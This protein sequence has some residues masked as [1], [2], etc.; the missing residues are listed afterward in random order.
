MTTLD[1][2]APNYAR[3]VAVWPTAQR[4]QN[5][6]IELQSAVENN[7]HGQTELIKSYIE[8]VCTTVCV[9]RGMEVPEKASLQNLLRLA[10]DSTGNR[11]PKD[12]SELSIVL[13]SFNSLCD[14]LSTA[15]NKKGTTA[16]GRDGFL[17]GIASDHAK[18]FL[19]VGDLLI[20]AVIDAH[21]AKVP[22]LRFTRIPHSNFE[23]LNALI[24]GRAAVAAAV[25]ADSETVVVLRFSLSQ[26]DRPFELRLQLSQIL[27]DI[28]RPL[29]LQALELAR[30]A[31]EQEPE[32]SSFDGGMTN[33]P[34]E[35][36]V[37]DS[38]D[39]EIVAESDAEV[40][41]ANGLVPLVEF[42]GEDKVEASMS[43]S[44]FEELVR[45][46]KGQTSDKH[47]GA[48]LVSSLLATAELNQGLDWHL[49]TELVA[50][51]RIALR[52]VLT[53]FGVPKEDSLQLANAMVSELIS[54]NPKGFDESGG[55]SSEFR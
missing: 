3:A 33:G 46:W 25:E 34:P 9:D 4:L 6:N 42:V 35:Y 45:L 8:C 17:E 39:S 15:R 38:L 31:A 5:Y 21:Q 32:S 51:M 53:A 2:I 40:E 12:S 19:H 27:Y 22:E 10:L 20:G 26:D 48:D 50:R 37:D 14:A 55:C 52:R 18:A 7:E 13:N 24:D 43:R 41:G 47:P 36:G 29:Y 44:R 30:L 11:H 49:R 54:S 28:D 16:H 23:E 1:E